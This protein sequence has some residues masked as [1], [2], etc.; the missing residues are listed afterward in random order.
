MSS[1]LDSTS[2]TTE[3][4]K[5]L[6]VWSRWLAGGGFFAIVGCAASL[7]SGTSD[8]NRE[9][10]TSAIFWLAWSVAGAC[11]IA[12]IEICANLFW[13]NVL[14]W[15][16]PVLIFV[17]ILL[18]G[19]GAF[20]A[21]QWLDA[22]AENPQSADSGLNGGAVKKNPLRVVDPDKSSA[23]SVTGRSD[24][25]IRELFLEMVRRDVRREIHIQLG[26]IF[27]RQAAAM[28]AAGIAEE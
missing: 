3:A 27:Q 12:L 14:V 23:Q 17:Q 24:K 19:T 6:S 4:F 25:E 22:K 13:R 21:Y 2:G 18:L 28:T 16:G 20:Q 15:V 1:Y 11:A 8:A 10:I 9:A 26:D 7:S 5:A